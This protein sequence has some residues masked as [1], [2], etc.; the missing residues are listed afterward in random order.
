[1]LERLRRR[2]RRDLGGGWTLHAC[3]LDR[4]CD[5]HFPRRSRMWRIHL[6]TPWFHSGVALR[7]G[8]R[9]AGRLDAPARW[10][11]FGRRR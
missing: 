11:D 10:I 8:D 6:G 7:P 2:I 4:D 3:F 5:S 9:F 1:M